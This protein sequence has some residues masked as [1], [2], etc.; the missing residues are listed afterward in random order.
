MFAADGWGKWLN[1][2]LKDPEKALMFGDLEVNTLSS[3]CP[4][5]ARDAKRNSMACLKN[6][7]GK[8][9]L[10]TPNINNLSGTWSD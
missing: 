9:A 6:S 7:K 3:R 1:E 10:S 2:R 5:R 4:N 8:L